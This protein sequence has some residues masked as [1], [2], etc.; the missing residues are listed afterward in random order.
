[1]AKAAMTDADSMMD[2][3]PEDF[4]ETE[5]PV[6]LPA[7]SEVELKIVSA[8]FV[9]SERTGRKMVSLGMSIV[10]HNV[11]D[12]QDSVLQLVNHYLLFLLPDDNPQTHNFA[13]GDM[14]NFC[15]AFDTEREQFVEAMSTITPEEW[16]S[17]DSS[18][19]FL[20]GLTGRALLKEDVYEGNF[21]NT[22]GKWF[23]A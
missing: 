14:K 5:P 7:G 15:L 11:E 3:L 8:K 19:E 16:L 22:V 21:K 4:M 9:T 6:Y 17:G 20:L 12:Y 13:M 1:M 18:V 10:E 23:E 2:L